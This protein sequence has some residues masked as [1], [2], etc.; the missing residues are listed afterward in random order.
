MDKE[1]MMTDRKSAHQCAHD[2]IIEEKITEEHRK[3]MQTN[4]CVAEE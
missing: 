1:K 4:C 2:E 3:W